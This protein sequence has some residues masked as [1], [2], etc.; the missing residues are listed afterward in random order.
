MVA[1]LPCNLNLPDAEEFLTRIT[2]G[3][4]DL[5]EEAAIELRCL[6]PQRTP[7]INRYSPD[8]MGIDLLIDDAA[9]ANKVGLSCYPVINPVRANAPLRRDGKTSGAT[10]ADIIAARF[11]W[12]DGDDEAATY[13][14]KNFAGPK[15]TFAVTTGR[16]PIV[17]P[18]IYWRLEEWVTDLSEWSRVQQGIAAQLSTDKTVVNPS[19]IMRLPGTINWPT[20]QKAAKGRVPELVTLRTDY[21]E[22]RDPVPYARMRRVFLGSAPHTSQATSDDP[23]APLDPPAP[24]DRERARIQALSGQ[25]WHNAVIR[26]VASYVSKGLSD[27]EIHGLTQPLTLPG[28]TPDQTRQEVQ[29]AIDGA[30]RKG[31]TPEQ[32]EAQ[33]KQEEQAAS[34]DEKPPFQPWREIDV[35]AMPRREFVYGRH[36]I[37][38]FASVTVAPGGLG[39][40]TL[41]LAECIAI[42]TGRPILGVTPAKRERVVYYN[43]EDPRD[44][45][46]RRVIAM[47]MHHGIPQSEIVGWLFTASGR[48]DELTLATGEQ[49]DI[50]E[51]VFQFIERWAQG[52]KPGVF[53]FDPLANMT[54]SPETNDVFR[55]LGKRLSRMADTLNCSIEIVHHTRKL[56][57]REAE[58]EDSRGGG[59]LLGAVRAGRVLNPMKPEE[60]AKAGLDTHI[61]FFRIE[62]AGKNNLARP[63][64]HATWYRR[65]NVEI[66][67]GDHVAALEE[68]QWPDAFDGVSA[69]DA[70]RVQLAIA[71]MEADPPRESIQSTKW[72]GHVVADVLGFDMKDKAEKAKVS[73]IV[74]AWIKSDVLTVEAIYDTRNGRD[75]KV[76]FPG[77]NNPAAEVSS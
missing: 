42:A 65:V 21:D 30:R 33:A 31:W 63:S 13:A 25:E 43:A 68:W 51:P 28:Y 3:W 38:K 27:D 9:A 37:R 57:G 29:T 5:P 10:D 18:H 47:L 77:Q 69:N 54:E 6:F 24:L 4:A 39:K 70:R 46:E 49:G 71:E 73:Q 14:I 55:K 59:A 7:I 66:P 11:C 74:R 40:S 67:N 60:A 8:P 72:V 26:L 58:I 32:V 22:P 44:E 61:D 34:F 48:E 15:Y 64:P 1:N 76:V 45:I 56:N 53:A 36:Y 16:T 19:R 50:A 62:A 2:E 35:L 23:F 75:V 41:V 52:V 17:R 20:T 12:A